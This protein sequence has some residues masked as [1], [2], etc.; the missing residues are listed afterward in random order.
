[1]IGYDLDDTLAKVDW[2]EAS[3]RGLAVIFAQAK[4]ITKPRD[5]FIVITARPHGTIALRKATEDWLQANQPNYKGTYYVSGSETEIIQGKARI[6]KD[7]NLTGF[8][9]NN[10]D[11]LKALK[12][13]NLGVKLYKATAKGRK[14][15]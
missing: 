6:I 8:V 14:A 10:T 2:N 13:L 3:T 9:D 7:H 11:I 1:M 15:F 5:P 12:D 4:V